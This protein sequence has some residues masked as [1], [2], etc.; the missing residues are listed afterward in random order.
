MTIA[1]EQKRWA[2]EGFMALSKDGHRN[3]IGCC[4]RKYERRIGEV[5]AE[6]YLQ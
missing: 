6:R 2:D 1:F 5:C 4:D 3:R